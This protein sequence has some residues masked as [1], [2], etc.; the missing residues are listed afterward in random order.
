MVSCIKT[1]DCCLHVQLKVF[2]FCFLLK[3]DDLQNSD[4]EYV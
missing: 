3:M 1:S 4:L 2:I